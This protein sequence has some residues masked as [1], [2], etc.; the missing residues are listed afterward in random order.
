ML[1]NPVRPKLVRKTSVPLPYNTPSLRKENNGQDVSTQLVPS[2]V[3]GWGRD[4]KQ[5]KEE[6]AAEAAAAEAARKAAQVAAVAARK[7]AEAKAKTTS[8]NN[9]AFEHRANRRQQ[10]TT[11]WPNTS[12]R[13]GII[14]VASFRGGNWPVRYRAF[15]GY[16]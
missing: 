12:R 16:L 4:T 10:Q 1:N 5:Q 7:A 9:R 2:G 6:E 3:G 8:T 14:A 11:F 13:T 15:S